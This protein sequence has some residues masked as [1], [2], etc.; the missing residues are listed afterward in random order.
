MHINVRRSD[1]FRISVTHCQLWAT[2]FSSYYYKIQHVILNKCN[3]K[4]VQRWK[5][6]YHITL[7]KLQQDYI[8][9][10]IKLWFQNRT[11]QMKILVL[12]LLTSGSLYS[13][14][15]RCIVIF[16]L[17]CENFTSINFRGFNDLCQYLCENKKE[18]RLDV[19]IT[20]Y[21]V[22]PE[23]NASL[24]EKLVVSKVKWS[25]T[26]GDL[27]FRIDCQQ[28]PELKISCMMAYLS[29]KTGSTAYTYTN[30]LQL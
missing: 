19:I 20:I 27:Q 21:I 26:T 1:M 13:F 3:T 11:Y 12:Y 29:L 30:L 24:F 18:C 2:D 17:K 22:K 8:A 28:E 7:F 4:L 9:I 16:R 6:S 10:A 15:V 25:M 5:T 14:S 23:S